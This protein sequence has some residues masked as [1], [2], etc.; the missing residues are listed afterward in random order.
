MSK[1]AVITDSISCIPP[2][3]LKEYDILVIP[4]GMIINRKVYKDT[5]L[6]N[7]EFWKL[8]YATKENITTVAINPAEFE[9]TFTELAKKTDSVVLI[10]MSRLLS[11]THNAGCQAKEN[12][13]QK[14]PT[15]K[16]EVIDSKQTTGAEGFIV[17]EAARAAQAGKT[18]EEVVAVAQ[19]L[20]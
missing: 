10:T 15:L 1:V 18:L 7:A 5:D 6:T 4:I 17:L 3:L 12:L 19:A 13:K 16:I 2:E 14:Q 9:S 20:V 11:S 8:F